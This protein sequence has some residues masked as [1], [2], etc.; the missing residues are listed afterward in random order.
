MYSKHVDGPSI[1]GLVLLSEVLE[2][3]SDPPIPE[4]GNSEGLSR[5]VEEQMLK[6]TKQEHQNLSIPLGSRC[7]F[8]SVSLSLW[9]SLSLPPLVY[10]SWVDA[11][12]GWLQAGGRVVEVRLFDPQQRDP[13]FAL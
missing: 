8:A 1:S 7:V 12:D 13:I 10:S 3:D 6:Q 5:G 9:V 11:E 2:E 4:L